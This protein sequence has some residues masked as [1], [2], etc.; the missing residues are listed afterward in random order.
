MR[1]LLDEHRE[2]DPSSTREALE[3]IEC[4][5]ALVRDQ[6][7]L[8]DLVA[9]AAQLTAADVTV[10]DALNGRRHSTSLE[11][12]EPYVAE[13]EDWLELHRRI[14]HEGNVIETPAGDVVT[15]SI[16]AGSGHIGAVFLSGAPALGS[17][18]DLLVAERL[19]AAVAVDA[20]RHRAREQSDARIDP[21]AVERLLTTALPAGESAYFARRAGLSPDADYAVLAIDEAGPGLHAPDVLA[22]TLLRFLAACD[23]TARGCV[24][25]R[26]ATVVATVGPALTTA[27]AAL[28]DA[29]TSMTLRAGVG[30]AQPI[31]SIAESH[32]QALDA[33][34]LS[35]AVGLSVVTKHDDVGVW[36]LL[37][38]IPSDAILATPDVCAVSA[39]PAGKD[40]LSD[41]ELLRVLCSTGSLRKTAEHVHLHHSSVHYRVQKIE[42][43]LGFTLGTP[44]GRERAMLALRLLSV[45]AVVTSQ[46]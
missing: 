33:L 2:V 7:D 8:T 34:L 43:H 14:E 12:A 26:R 24:V 25:D 32:D 22:E 38:Q 13:I 4:F 21:A 31:T 28:E 11:S 44:C 16:D 15:A 37:L 5:D 6:A 1:R 18:R 3:V 41:R 10:E 17:I 29:S 23:V 36:G 30:S 39:L 9:A 20:L 46:R 27:L 35:D 45:V 40:G 42:S 19:A